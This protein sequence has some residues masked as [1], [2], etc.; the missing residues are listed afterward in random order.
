MVLLLA[1]AASAPADEMNPAGTDSEADAVASQPGIQLPKS[2]MHS[3]SGLFL[4]R[5][6]TRVDITDVLGLAERVAS[7]I[8]GAL[9]HP[10]PRPV[11][12]PVYIELMPAAGTN[13]PAAFARHHL[14]DPGGISHRLDVWAYENAAPEILVRELVILLLD[15][16]VVYR[17]DPASQRT[18]ARSLP[19]QVGAGLARVLFP[20]LREQAARIAYDAW[21]MGDA[22]DP[23]LPL[24]APVTGNPAD[25]AIAGIVTVWMR[26]RRPAALNELV[27]QTARADFPTVSE[28]AKLLGF[29]DSG[30]MR[31]DWHLWMAAQDSK[32][33]PWLLS[34]AQR[35]AQLRDA[36]RL[37]RAQWP[38]LAPEDAP[39]H[40]TLET[41]LDRR[42]EAWVPRTALHMIGQIR[43]VPTGQ[44]PLLDRAAKIA[45]H[46]LWEMQYPQPPIP[47]RWLLY[48]TSDRYIAGKLDRIHQYL[49][50]VE[51]GEPAP[52]P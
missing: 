35:A 13:S 15:R 12:Y 20:S 10:I 36:M 22:S 51:A 9:L 14:M 38:D 45:E 21:V 23:V 48:R 18:A 11:G 44:L 26:E 41:L 49:S 25:E 5:G 1:L 2:W 31:R 16:C 8:E 29:N 40:L 4:C 52:V 6:G 7:R 19:P 17:Q 28:L 43:S 37:D 50:Q 46:V 42:G 47:L 27:T 34:P 33:K 24:S 39:E 30:A 32:L 3:A